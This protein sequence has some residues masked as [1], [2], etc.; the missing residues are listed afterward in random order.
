MKLLLQRRASQGDATVGHL[1][2]N[3][4]H[5]CYTLE[6]VVREI[7]G[8]PVAEW[9][10]K[11]K[12]AI[13]AGIYDVELQNSPK[14]G[15]DCLTVCDVPGFSYIRMHAGNGSQ[16]TEGCILLGTQATDRTL[17]GGSSRPA[18]AMVRSQV[19]AA[20]KLGESVT[21]EIKNA[22]NWAQSA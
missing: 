20:R 17:V 15:A 22:P 14:Y 12:T 19:M 21:I 4:E 1:Y 18:V 7:E 16:D 13:P 11:G 3:G 8:A 10:V 9:K 6:D 2:I 5:A